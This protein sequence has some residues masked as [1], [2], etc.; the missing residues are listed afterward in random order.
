MDKETMQK[1]NKICGMGIA[2]FVLSIL[3]IVTMCYIVFSVI[4]GILAVVLGALSCII[5][6]KNSMGIAGLIVG[7]ISIFTTIVLYITLGVMDI[8]LLYIP[9]YYKF[10]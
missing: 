4:F 9:E 10:F 6:K 5:E 1:S 3:S 8:D 7:I 2:S